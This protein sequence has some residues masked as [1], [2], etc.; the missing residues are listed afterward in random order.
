[1]PYH[2]PMQTTKS[3]FDN[4]LNLTVP[5]TGF[6]W[7]K[8]ASITDFPSCCGA[9]TG[10]Q[11]KLVPDSFYGLNVSP[12]CWVHDQMFALAEPTWVD[13][14]QCNDIFL[15]NLKTIIRFH[16]SSAFIK[17]LRYIRAFEYYAAVITLARNVYP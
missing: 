10:L 17:H 2:P 6:M 8:N 1:M 14:H 3:L 11:E 9:G 13:F 7:P 16:N 4:K 12:A 5:T 15:D